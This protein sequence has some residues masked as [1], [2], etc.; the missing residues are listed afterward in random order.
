VR[1]KATGSIHA[2]V[3]QRNAVITGTFK[4]KHIQN[5]TQAHFHIGAAG[6]NGPVGAWIWPLDSEW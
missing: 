4:V 6:V 1:T 3:D 5:V 2:T